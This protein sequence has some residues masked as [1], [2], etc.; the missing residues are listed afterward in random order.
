MHVWRG[1]SDLV[2]VGTGSYKHINYIVHRISVTVII[3]R[4]VWSYWRPNEPLNFCSLRVCQIVLETGVAMLWWCVHTTLLWI[5]LAN[6]IGCYCWWLSSNCDGR[7]ITQQLVSCSYSSSNKP[8]F[9][10]LSWLD[11]LPWVENWRRPLHWDLPPTCTLHTRILSSQSML[12][13]W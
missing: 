1:M 10:P 2:L 9:L 7:S 11:S 12:R 5:S 3:S 13:N 8:C 4:M 6:S